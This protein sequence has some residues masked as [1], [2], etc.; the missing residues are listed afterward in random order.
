[1]WL[2]FSILSAATAALMTIVGKLGLKGVDPTFATG[3]RSAVMFLF[4]M[5]VL[6]IS[7]KFKLLST[8]DHKAFWTIVISAMFGALSWMFYFI[9]LKDASASKVAAID[10]LSLALVIVFSI[11]VLGEK[12]TWKLALGSV[13]STIG[14]VLIALG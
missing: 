5:G 12:L 9:A 2:I 1:M 7:G 8:L 10:R 11:L 3:I 14:I 13:L 6:V 4:M